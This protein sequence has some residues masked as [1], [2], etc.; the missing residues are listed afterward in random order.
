MVNRS[1][2]STNQ[3]SHAEDDMMSDNKT[4]LMHEATL[5]VLATYDSIGEPFSLFLSSWSFDETREIV[6]HISGKRPRNVQA[7]IGMER[8]VRI[9]LQQENLETIS[10]YRRGDADRIAIPDEWPALS[11]ADDEWQAPVSQIAQR[12]DLIV[13]FWGAT[14]GGALARG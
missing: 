8:Q 13:L 10:I 7:R 5:R 6:D 14:T 1:Q 11:L 3:E 12:A 2:Y 9:L 4:K